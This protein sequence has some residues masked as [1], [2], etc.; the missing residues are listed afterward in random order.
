[1]TWLPRSLLAACALLPAVAGAQ[2]L[3]LW[4]VGMLGGVAS[5]PAYPGSDDRSTRS[6]VLPFLIYR[7]D[8]FRAD[9]S[10]VGMRLFRS[11][12]VQLDVGLAAS[13][14]ARSDDVS[15]RAGMPDL[16]TLLEFGPR[17][18]VQLTKPTPNSGLRLD[19]P[20]RAVIEARSGLRTQ[21]MTFEPKLVYEFDAPGG[22]WG[23]DSNVG[24]VLG[25]R[26]VNRYFYEVQPQFATLERPAYQADSGLM[27][28][29]AGLSGWTMINPDLRVFGF[30]RYESYANAANRDSPL[31]KQSTGA[32]AGFGFAWT[33]KRSARLASARSE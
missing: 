29:R 25:D 24:V 30:M 27:L 28:V 20:L 22:G 8:V 7:G 14:P 18:K 5:T 21:G 13:L 23:I 17:I 2:N 26:K 11:D 31:L 10:G 1:M 19:L 4:E 15:A 33:I 6:I 3:P 16:G 9:Q 12:R 32:S